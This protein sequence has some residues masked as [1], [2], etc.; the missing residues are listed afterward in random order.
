MKCSFRL[1]LLFSAALLFHF[2]AGPQ[3]T[4][5]QSGL[6][7]IQF[8]TVNIGA[9][10]APVAVSLTFNNVSTLGA[11][12]VLTA[13]SSGLDFASAGLGSCTSNSNGAGQC[14]VNVTFAPEFPGTRYGAVI[15]ADGSGTVVATGY[16]QGTGVG[17][18]V[19][20]LPGTE[21]TI[22]ANTLAY[23]SSVA[24]DGNGSVYIADSGNNRVLKETFLN[25]A[26]SQSTITTSALSWI[27]GLAVD[28]SGSIYLADSGN[29]RVL[30]ETLSAGSY[31]ETTIPTSTLSWPSA[32]AADGSGNVYI[33]DS[34][35]NRVLMESLSAGSYTEST[36]PTSA[37]NFPTSVSVDGANNIYIADSGNSRVLKEVPVSGNYTESAVPNSST[38]PS[39]VAID[40]PGDVYIADSTN[41]RILKE[42]FADP[43]SLS[44]APTV[45]GSTSSDSPK[46]VTVENIGN[47][48]LSFPVPN[49]GSNPSV[50]ANFSLNTG[51]ASSCPYIT[52][53]PSAGTL[54]AGQSC[55]L[56]ISFAPTDSGVFGGSL[57]LTDNALNVAASQSIELSGVGTGSIQQTISFSPITAQPASSTVTLAASTSSGLLVS[58]SSVTPA[59][60]TV[61][62]ATASLIAA[63][64]CSIQASQPGNN[65]YAAATP[66]IQ[67][68]TVN[69]APQTITFAAIPTQAINTSVPVALIATA[70]SGLPV[71]FGS[72]TP[73]ICTVSFS[74]ATLLANGTC[75]IQASQPG[76]G[77]VFAASATV[78][79]SFVVASVSQSTATNFGSVNIGS[80]SSIMAVNLELNVSGTLASTTV[81]TRG[82]TGLD[83]ANAGAGTCAVGTNYTAGSACTVPVKFTPS[84]AGSR[85]GAVILADGAGNALAI[86]YIEGIGAGPQIDFLPGTESTIPA[87]TLAFPSGVAQDDSGNIYIA[88]TGNNRVLREAPSTNGYTQT[89][90]PSSALASPSAVAVDAAGNIYIADTGNNRVLKEMPTAGSYNEITV[91]TSQLN[92][93]NGLAVDGSGN[94]YIADTANN[95][96]LMETFSLGSYFESVIPTSPLNYPGAV[97][98]DESGDV[99]IVDS[100]NNRIVLEAA[101]SG[102]YTESV[103]QTS[104]L[105]YTESIAVD[106]GANVYIADTYNNRVL[107]ETASSGSYVE[108]TVATSTLSGPS[109]VTVAGNGNIVIAD[110]YNNRIAK[111]D[112]ADSPSLSFA[113]TA[114]G[115]TSSDSPQTVTVE[116]SGNTALSFSVPSSGNNPSIPANFALNSGVTSACPLVSAGSSAQGT[117][118]SGQFCLLPIGFTPG[119]PGVFNTSLTLSDSALNA[120]STQ[121]ILLSG[122]GTGSTQQTITFSTISARFAGSALTLT[123]TASSGLPVSY[124]SSTPSV[125]AVSGVAA[126]LIAAGTCTIQA[127]QAGD[128]VYAPAPSVTQSFAVNLV[129][130]TIT[131][132]SISNQIINTSAPVTLAATASSGL[133][134][135]FTSSTTSVCTVSGQTTVLIAAG[136]CTIQASQP[137]DGAV[138]AAAPPI[139]Q[140][141]TVT[142][143]SPS[144]S[145]NFGSVNVASTS[146]AKAVTL[147]FFTT[148]T[149]GSISVVTQ[150]ATGLDF[151]NAGGGTCAAGTNYNAGSSCTVTVNFTPAFPGSRYGA[152]FLQ[153]GAGNVIA[154]SYLQGTGVGPQINFLP[155]TES[156]L[157]TSPLAYPS[158]LAV[159][160]SGN[161]YI[162][163]TGNNR[164]LKETFSLGSYAEATLPT[165]VLANP[166]GIALDG[167]GN[168]YLTDTD[169]NR[170]L[171]EVWAASQYVES[172]LPT[173]ALQYPAAVAV[174]GSGNVYIADYGNNRVLMETPS[175]GS[176]VEIVL[177]TST[178]S[179]PSGVAADASGNVYIADTYYNR[180]LKETL[181]SGSYT[182][183]TITTTP[184]SYPFGISVDGEG[185]VYIADTYNNRILKEAP[186]AGTYIESTVSA[187][188]LNAPAGLA[189]GA[190]GNIYIADT[191]NS[192]ALKEDFADSPSLTFANAAPGSTS[193]DSPQTVTIENA[194]NATLNFPIPG[195]GTNPAIPANFTLNSNGAQTCSL[196]SAGSST[197]GALASEQS[198]TLPISFAPTASGVFSG[199]LV[200]T[201]NVLN[202]AASQTIQLGGVGTGSTGQTIDFSPIAT[203]PVNSTVALVASASSGLP[204]GF[205]STSLA[206]C[207]VAGTTVSLTA[208]GTCT[209]QANQ[210]GNSV[211]ATAT[212]VIQSFTVSLLQQTITFASIPTQVINTSLPVALTVTASSGLP[213]TL[214][215][216][217]PTICTASSSAAT[218]LA[219]GTCMIQAS[220]PGDGAVYAAA[221]TI[222]QSFLAASPS[223]QTSANFGSVNVAATSTAVAV[224]LNMPTAATLGSISVVT[225]GA[226]GLDFAYV[227]GGT[228]TVGTNYDGGS[229]CTVTV[230]FTP[231]SAG[232]R[233]GAV[234]L[235]D[236]AGNTI[237]TSYLQGTG[238]GPQ[239]NF[240]PGAEST[241]ATSTLEW[242]TGVAT[243]AGGNVY[244]VDGDNN[245]LVKETLS[246]GTYT[247][248]TV[249]TS[250][251]AYPY[252]VTVD[253]NGNIYVDDSGNN[254]ILKETLSGGNYVE[255][256]IT[257]SALAFPDGVAIDGSGN[258]Y[259][260]D[261]GNNRVL[262]ET[263]SEGQYT[264]SVLPTSS[265]NCPAGIAVDG[266][267][268]V[269]F[270]DSGNNRVLEEILSTGTYAESVIPTSALN[271]PLSI[272][273]DSSGN[274]YV[275]DSGNNRILKE[276]PSAGKYTEETVSS[277]TLNFPDSIAVDGS[278]NVYIAD[279]GN[280]RI[281]KEDFADPPIL[282]FANTTP[283]STSSDSP[284]TITVENVGNATLNLP[285]PSSGSN[286]AISANFTLG[287]TGAQ[288]C[289][290]IN[291]GSSTVGQLTVAQSCLLSVSFT[292]VTGG[293]LSGS[294][295]LSDNSLNGTATQNIALNGSGTDPLQQTITFSSISALSLTSDAE[296]TATSSSGL[297]VTFASVTPSVCAILAP[298]YVWAETAGTCTIQANQSGNTV[299]APAPT[300]TQSST[301]NLVSQTIGYAQIPSQV[302][303]A[304]VPLN[305]ASWFSASSTLP[306]SFTT[307]TPT[308]CTASS[309]T[310]KATLLT[311]GTC[312]I[313][314]NQSGDG[315][316]FAAAPTVAMS[317]TVESAPPATSTMFNAVN[318]GSVSS[319]I[320]V[321]LT[322][323]TAS[324]VGSIS[325]V[326]QGASGLDFT[327]A[328]SG[329]CSVGTSYNA[330]DTCT[331][332][333][334][335]TPLLSGSRYGEVSL[336][337]NSGN[338]IVSTYLQGVGV[339]PAIEYLPGTESTVSTST[340]SSPFGVAVDG[341][342]NLY[343]ADTWNNRLLKETPS[344]GSYVESS[345]Q[346][347]TP[348]PT[349]VAVDGGGNLYIA[350][351]SSNRIVKETVSASGYT[352]TV[353]QTS[354][355]S[356]P[357]ALVVDGSGNLYIADSGNNRV[358]VEVP[359]AGAYTETILPTS[360]LNYP[361]GIAVDGSG[362]VYISDTYN[363]RVLK[364]TASQIGYTES[365]LPTSAEGPLGIAVDSRGNVYISDDYYDSSW[366]PQNV[367]LRETV[368]AGTYSEST[369]V[370]SALNIP[371]GIAVD[372]RG[373]VYIAD[374]GNN[375]VLK[376]DFADPPSV[377]FASTAVGATST[378]SPQ[379]VTV[380]NVGNAAL[381][382]VVPGSGSNPNVPVNFT[383]NS[384]VSQSCP[385]V[386]A[387]S[388]VAGILSAGQNCLLNISFTPA[389]SGTLNGALVL[390]NNALN[391]IAPG[392][393][394]QSIQLNGTGTQGQ[395]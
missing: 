126:S 214:S 125:C 50:A 220:Q 34:G 260:S 58:F 329:T 348:Y 374:T 357:G 172:T 379:A 378:D 150:G 67:S 7:A 246:S 17:P 212:P 224:T 148:A 140:S 18:Q 223:L 134:V 307:T 294:I 207:T 359:S 298:G 261:C 131:F 108:S 100:G 290:I 189:A 275:G 2:V 385:L 186:S 36:I 106:G 230:S 255:S 115:S 132:T 10:S 210:P 174:D 253:G 206:V 86:A 258:V 244:V 268:D 117:L 130:Q 94:V 296:L 119:A 127:S 163:D 300:V 367:V 87:S 4:Y 14:T 327:N 91:P 83:F 304:S 136:T 113:P 369:L 351:S 179:F 371:D 6:S 288:S 236:G 173:S 30:K 13:G 370:T 321:S 167:S 33:S 72:T 312:T 149:L 162:A 208:G 141:F 386:N 349:A 39:A 336:L 171:K 110:T 55:T 363:G 49:G 341:S 19:N 256:A 3:S 380:E 332:S 74:A 355:L 295:V 315:K 199:A 344:S 301:V 377:N 209:I 395:Q 291:A 46:T 52:A 193:V 114:P 43:P 269:Y 99:Y 382:F 23:P 211:Y 273:V 270:V 345:I 226:S 137:G 8:G 247:Q 292:P 276:V 328:G 362:N 176:Y 384:S 373:N 107:K 283:G 204:V 192:R 9:T 237:A 274:I 203:Q 342:G 47:A 191:Y 190:N 352:E 97:A 59:V 358:L 151:A 96:V 227:G 24:L 81:L 240:L 233:Y 376:E 319:P 337:D 322:F 314:A 201:D 250:A 215:S 271:Q 293:P 242:P 280:D 122:T 393:A 168:L 383:L 164:L 38:W 178:L 229:N 259:V 29:N 394:V 170:V 303:N 219:A 88:D 69:L 133:P 331:V 368:S 356:Y 105:N 185:D 165:S 187:S 343:I 388:S 22:P 15:L 37:L 80:T 75:T 120:A 310:S 339:G 161:V 90:V 231:S 354:A 169:N 143:V 279:A 194:G 241:L 147:N 228:C 56:P 128:P 317:F 257:T 217:T 155:G 135:V 350:D 326:S 289:P 235:L 70:S 104:P 243:D 85:Y 308:V 123:A 248:S 333:V 218:L 183:S 325:V 84:F 323:G 305:L 158:G 188:I 225:Q 197:A 42:D 285:V 309:S 139:T 76:D 138:Y 5:G 28:A 347:G 266:H 175:S 1:S 48:V 232:S 157:S 361:S 129:S 282:N 60:C 160:A 334:T 200:L 389:Q 32:V 216:T 316:V 338:M 278:G 145:T 284:Q 340:L 286:P 61:A 302:I 221:P 360:G 184:L 182:E 267:G 159:D 57:V 195:S 222:T 11:V 297:P 152:A 78:T 245:S 390:T 101:S 299:Y 381:D 318:I 65:V 249:S 102:S 366:N 89:V 387:G 154:T 35:N 12:S 287:N 198:C 121:N 277:S 79:Q 92:W 265:L 306:V 45:P 391:A 335:F 31:V 71:G 144:T 320:A 254:R 146:S 202:V 109:G 213:V 272:A 40:G 239:V 53:G 181:S 375:R 180:V 62:G 25:G 21:I 166:A 205:N 264:E 103:I 44:F 73:T 51:G 311:A 64:T 66:A 346:I 324:T 111:E 93:P 372:P 41:N 263:L 118:A 95:R 20:F 196:I 364:E 392:F 124:T 156:T 82:A 116:N 353:V 313:Q 330:G 63:G 142:S 112:L 77:V 238:I 26:Y 234:S 177:P 365:V 251:L 153:D 98:I 16:L 262:M 281:L 68:F 54:D 252:A 27:S